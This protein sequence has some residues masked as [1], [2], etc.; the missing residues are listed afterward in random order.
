MTQ[1]EEKLKNEQEEK[2]KQAAEAKRQADAAANNRE[3]IQSQATTEL[4]RAD[5]IAERQARENTR[6]EDI[7][8]RE[9]ALEARRRVGGLS[10][11]GQAPQTPKDESPKEYRQRVEK[12]MAA[13]KTD[14]GN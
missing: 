14:F 6:R 2:E 10:E 1:E 13:G 4:D 3:G 5:Q 7:L 8:K 11:A 12:E 9:E